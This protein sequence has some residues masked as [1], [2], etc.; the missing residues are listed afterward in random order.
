[1]LQRTLGQ[2]R[3]GRGKKLSSANHI[4]EISLILLKYVSIRR[5]LNP[6]QFLQISKGNNIRNII[7]STLL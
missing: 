1:M 6:Y 5:I 3:Y 2:L 4:D 7:M